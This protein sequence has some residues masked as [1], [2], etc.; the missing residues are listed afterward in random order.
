MGAP[1]KPRGEGTR[2]SSPSSHPPIPTE[3]QIQQ[4]VIAWARLSE[5]RFPDLR[6]LHHI[7]NGGSRGHQERYVRKGGRLV[8]ISYSPETQRLKREGLKPGVPDLDS[9]VA[10]RGYI[11]LRIEMKRPGEKNDRE[12][13]LRWQEDL[14]A[15]GHCVV[16][17]WTFDQARRIIE[18]YALGCRSS[19]MNAPEELPF[20][21]ER[22][23]R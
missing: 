14:R 21:P 13:Q 19:L 18:W 15:A 10:R 23:T 17:C 12:D 11:G 4:D 2:S 22:V 7:P 16:C 3:S 1:K 8:K 5:G 20:V 9:P 6:L